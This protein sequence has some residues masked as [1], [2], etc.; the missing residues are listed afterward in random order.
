MTPLA[1]LQLE[2]DE[3]Y[4]RQQGNAE[5]RLS[6]EDA[7][8]LRYFA[9]ALRNFL[10]LDPLYVDG[11]DERKNMLIAEKRAARLRGVR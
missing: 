11:R 2:I 10:G 6:K 1:L 4:Y 7:E 3:E 9:N 5:I 8:H